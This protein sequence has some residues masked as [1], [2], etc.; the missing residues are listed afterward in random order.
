MPGIFA[1]LSDEDQTRIVALVDEL[2]RANPDA[3]FTLRAYARGMEDGAGDDDLI[4]RG[5][6]VGVV[7]HYDGALEA[8]M[9]RIPAVAASRDER[10]DDLSE[11]LE[12][13]RKTSNTLAD[14]LSE[15]GAEMSRL[16]NEAQDLKSDLAFQTARADELERQ[17]ARAK[18]YID[19]TLD[20]E[21]GRENAEPKWTL[22]RGA[23][24]DVGPDIGRVPSRTRTVPSTWN[25]EA[26]SM[27]ASVGYEERTRRYR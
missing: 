9:R 5:D 27:L 13:E 15:T 12:S 26:G 3:V 18:G 25:V 16:K 7:D 22:E 2:S 24:S 23:A 4:R 20:E 19:R 6:A 1:Q 10:A 14:K 21:A 17:L 11:A 8:M